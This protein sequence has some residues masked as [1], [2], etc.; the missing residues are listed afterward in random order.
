MNTLL[1]G[2]WDRSLEHY[3][4]NTRRIWYLALAVI[5]TITLYYET[6]TLA[7]VVPLVQ[8]QFHLSLSQYVYSVV[9]ANLLGALAA[10]LASLSDRIGRGNLIV[11]GLL[12]T[13]ACTLAISLA[14]SLWPFLLLYWV[15]G[16]VQGMILTV[17][18]ALV[19][20]FSP[21]LGR[22]AA[23]GFW[24]IGPVGGN[25]L[26]ALVASLTL[27]VYHSWHSQYVIA[28]GVGLVVFL[29]CLV[30][31]RELSPA[32]RDQ[33]MYTLRDKALVEARA[34]QIDVESAL[35]HPW[36]Q[37]LRPRLLINA[38]GINLFLLI[39]FVAKSFFVIYLSTSFAFPLAQANG[40]VSVFFVVI[41]I[42]TLVVG[43]LSDMMRV[44]KPLLLVGATALIIVT[45]LF[46]SRIGQP[47]STV[48]MTVLL[49]LM[50]I[51][52]SIT[53]VPWVAAY[54][55]TVEDINPAL[56]AT[57]IAVEVFISRLVAVIAILALPVVVG[58][59][60]G[61]GAWWWVCIAGQVIFLPTILATSG[62]WNPLRARVVA[63]A[64]ERAE[65]L[66]AQPKV[67]SW[68][69]PS[70]LWPVGD[71]GETRRRRSPF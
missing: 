56:V 14:T 47:T 55:E 9:L 36:R 4:A 17:T 5:A 51:C 59:G 8:A 1:N 31:L 28:G 61:W 25:F 7:S 49:A 12:V 68:A 22:A 41:V 40:M 67:G 63:R 50:G 52:I 53:F 16:F 62:P 20:D 18:P 48:V 54:T 10:L 3:P 69:A 23:M 2:L 11:S 19:R 13:D 15:L 34:S 21:R 71:E 66:E 29:V 39:Y 24:T 46:L 32:L 42:S 26:A 45:L 33:V 64:R 57:G 30:G 43:F 6:F 38:L 27:P 44:R 58:N 35:R 65:S 70:W 60:Q 37:M